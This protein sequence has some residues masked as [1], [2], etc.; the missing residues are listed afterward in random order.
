MVGR[1]EQHKTEKPW[2]GQ[3]HFRVCLISITEAPEQRK[4]KLTKGVCS[5]PN[6]TLTISYS[7]NNHSPIL[8]LEPRV[9]LN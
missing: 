2:Q 8:G 5:S 7:Q 4:L 9:V 6:R 3:L 1:R